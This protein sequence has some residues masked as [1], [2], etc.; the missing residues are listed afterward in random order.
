MCRSGVMYCTPQELSGIRSSGG[1]HCWL[2][3][4]VQNRWLVFV[5]Q[6]VTSGRRG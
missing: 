2:W 4:L 5:C 6:R 1:V 3:K